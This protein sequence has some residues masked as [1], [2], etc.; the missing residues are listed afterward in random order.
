[1]ASQN[2]AS[3]RNNFRFVRDPR[4]IRK[5]RSTSRLLGADPANFLENARPQ[6]RLGHP[7]WHSTPI[8]DVI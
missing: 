8:L 7:E 2:G 3:S 1:M 4:G 5:S 6:L